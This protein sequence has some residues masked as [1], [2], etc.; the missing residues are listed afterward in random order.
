MMSIIFLLEKEGYLPQ[1]FV[2]HGTRTD[3]NYRGSIPCCSRSRMTAASGKSWCCS[4]VLMAGKDAMIS[5]L[6]PEKNFGGH[7]Y[8]EATFIYRAHTYGNAFE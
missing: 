4:Q 1:K 5:N 6:E 3:G 7:K 2:F 8:F